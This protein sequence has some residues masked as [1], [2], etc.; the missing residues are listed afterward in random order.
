MSRKVFVGG[1]PWATDDARLHDFFADCGEVVEAKVILERGT[2]RSRG[3]GFVTFDSPESAQ[4]ALAMDGQS[5]DGRTI[6]IDLAE[7]RPRDARGGG[8]R[9][10]FRSN[11][12]GNDRGGFGGGGRNEQGSFGSKH[13]DRGGRRERR[14]DR[15]GR[16]DNR[17]D[18][19]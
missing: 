3:F 1:L 16:R 10:G 18:R 7:E 11:D 9:G 8:D 15:G 5:L 2:N 17:D 14:D 6:K 13:D 12:R 4:K 19:W